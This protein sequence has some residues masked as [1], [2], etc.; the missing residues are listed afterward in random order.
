M[1]LGFKTAYLGPAG[2]MVPRPEHAA[3]L[4]VT[5]PGGGKSFDYED[6][7]GG[8]DLILLDSKLRTLRDLTT[9]SSTEASEHAGRVAVRTLEPVVFEDRSG[10]VRGTRRSSFDQFVFKSFEL[11][12]DVATTAV[13]DWLNE[14]WPNVLDDQG[15]QDWLPILNATTPSLTYP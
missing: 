11:P 4:L 13:V 15:L 7:R 3:L 9:A 14:T 12:T 5:H 10:S 8:S 6:Y 1:G 2:G